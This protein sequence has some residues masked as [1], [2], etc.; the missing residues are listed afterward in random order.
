MIS[1]NDPL[2][3]SEG[4]TSSTTP[5]PELS[6]ASGVSEMARKRSETV[7]DAAPVAVSP[8]S[9]SS[10]EETITASIGDVVRAGTTSVATVSGSTDAPGAGWTT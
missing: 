2:G 5:A 4:S 9:V 6:A 1:T 3:G 8:A 10:P 7:G